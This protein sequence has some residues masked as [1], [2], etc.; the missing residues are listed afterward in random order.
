MGKLVIVLFLVFWGTFV[1][2]YDISDDGHETGIPSIEPGQIEIITDEVPLPGTPD[3][4]LDLRMQVGGMSFGDYDNDGDLDLAVGCYHSQSYPPYNDWRNFVLRNNEGQLESSP[5]WWSTDSRS[6]TDIKWAD[7]DTNGYLDLFATNGDFSL[8]PN[9]IYFGSADGLSNAPGWLATDQTWTTGCD[10][11][12]FDNDGDIDMATSNQG[13][14]P[15]YNRPVYIYINTGEGLQTTPMWQSDDQ[16]LSSF[17]NWGDLNND[18]WP[19]LAVSKWVNFESCVYFNDEGTMQGTPVWTSGSTSGDKGIGWGDVDADSFP[20]LAIG[21]SEPTV[22]FD[23]IDGVL[24]NSPI[25]QSGNAFHGCQDLAWA[26]ID[27]DG[28]PDLATADFSNGHLNVYLNIDGVLETTA[29]WIY[30]GNGMGTALA[31]GDVNGDGLLDLA[32]GQSGQPCALLFLNNGE[33]SVN[34]EVPAPQEFTLKQ[35]YP[36]P[37][38]ATTRIDFEVTAPGWIS[39]DVYDILGNKVANI[40][41][42]DYGVG[43][44][45]ITWDAGNVASGIYFCKLQMNGKSIAKRMVLEK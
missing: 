35:N 16:M 30:D 42:S 31:F 7:F 34:D 27:H 38:N 32:M 19:D 2:G 37:F 25:W 6:T 18:G 10:P 21:G 33:V 3:Y 24:G 20:E 14:A 4:S 29:S 15:N 11:A 39:L 12:D 9:V 1:F 41:S 44:H 8:D 43:S 5:S 26:D 17:L 40:A 45:S 13:V 23:N 28:D 36:N 22:L